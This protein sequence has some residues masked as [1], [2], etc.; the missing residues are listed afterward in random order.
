M[1]EFILAG[2]LPLAAD[3]CPKEKA[4]HVAT[5]RKACDEGYNEDKGWKFAL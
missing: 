5:Q 2:Q 1:K 4:N 3:G